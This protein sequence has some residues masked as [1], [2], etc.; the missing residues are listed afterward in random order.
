MRFRPSARRVGERV[1]SFA[2]RRFRGAEKAIRTVPI[3]RFRG[4]LVRPRPGLT[5]CCSLVRTSLEA[6]DRQDMRG[7][8]SARHSPPEPEDLQMG[9]PPK[10]LHES[11]GGTVRAIRGY[12]G[13]TQRQF[14]SLAGIHHNYV[15]AIERGEGSPTLRLIESIARACGMTPSRLLAI[16][17]QLQED[18]LASVEESRAP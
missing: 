5:G 4:K 3:H 15:G 18:E 13:L 16:A 12:R 7:G 6:R 14:A 11:F 10:S 17:E 1:L 9:Q 2:G 8:S